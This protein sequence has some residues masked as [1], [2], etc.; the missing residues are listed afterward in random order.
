LGGVVTV[1]E[2]AIGALVLVGLMTLAA[3]RRDR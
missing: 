3:G 1:P 2:P